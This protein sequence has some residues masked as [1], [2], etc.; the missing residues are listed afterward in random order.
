MD[1][2]IKKDLIIPPFKG[3][4][5]QPFKIRNGVIKKDLIIPLLRGLKDNHSKLEMVIKKDLIIH[6]FKGIEGQP[7]K[8][9]N[10]NGV[11]GEAM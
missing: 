11:L 8:I 1:L 2:V 9:G 10:S 3:T 6:P 7:F 4:E 5:G